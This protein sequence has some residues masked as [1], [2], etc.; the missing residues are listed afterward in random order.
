M[1]LILYDAL[2]QL[3]YAYLTWFNYIL[4]L[5]SKRVFSTENRGAKFIYAITTHFSLP[6]SIYP[7]LLNSFPPSLCVQSNKSHIR[8]PK[9]HMVTV[10]CPS[11]CLFLGFIFPPF[12]SAAPKSI[13]TPCFCLCSPD[14]DAWS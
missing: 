11:D 1:Y 12:S 2:T 3:N 14:A 13:Y 8:F 5:T 9:G 4:S 7:L 10:H 6:S